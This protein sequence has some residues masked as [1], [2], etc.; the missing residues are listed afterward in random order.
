MTNLRSF[1]NHE[2]ETIS[3]FS[4]KVLSMFNHFKAYQ[5]DQALGQY[6]RADHDLNGILLF[7]ERHLYRTADSFSEAYNG[8][9]WSMEKG[10]W[11]LQSSVESIPVL[12]PIN[13]ISADLTP[14]EFS[15]IVNIFA[16]CELSNS[17]YANNHNLAGQFCAYMRHHAIL[18]FRNNANL[19]N[20]S[21]LEQIID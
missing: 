8:G 1:Y 14:L 10:F 12:I 18:L 19:V 13:G 9:Y 15:F 17:F 11:N 5:D 7:A 6:A 2:L 21:L 16:W 3:D 20:E 4:P